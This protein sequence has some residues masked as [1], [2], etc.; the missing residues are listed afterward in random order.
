[1][2][3]KAIMIFGCLLMVVAGCGKNIDSKVSFA[4]TD[5]IQSSIG[6]SPL[7]FE[8]SKGDQVWTAE[9]LDEIKTKMD[10]LLSTLKPLQ[11]SKKPAAEAKL[12]KVVEVTYPEIEIIIIQDQEVKLLSKIGEDYFSLTG[13]KKEIEQV[14]NIPTTPFIP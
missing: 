8:V 12:A 5:R 10:P 4:I 14:L 11:K 6:S 2:K 9:E 7:R 13:G 1:M 3:L